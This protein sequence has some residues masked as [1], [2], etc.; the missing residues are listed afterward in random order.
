MF[1]RLVLQIVKILIDFDSSSIAVPFWSTF[2]HGC[3]TFLQD[4]PFAILSS[5]TL[6]MTEAL[7]FC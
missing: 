1:Y 4:L 7:A 3:I 6:S 5:L 2:T